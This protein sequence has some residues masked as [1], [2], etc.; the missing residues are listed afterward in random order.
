MPLTVYFVR[1]ANAVREQGED[2]P[3][4]PLSDLGKK[5]AER[6]ARRLAD[7]HFDHI[8]SSSMLRAELTARLIHVYHKETPLSI[9]DDIR[10]VSH[11]H[12]I[13]ELLPDNPDVRA[14]IKRERDG[15]DRFVNYIHHNHRSGEHIL[16][17]CH[18][19]IMRTIIPVLSGKDP[20]QNVLMEFSNTSLSILDVWANGESVLILSN[21][22]KHLLAKQVT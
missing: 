18:G 15:V 19:N 7:F 5:Q 11:Y 8:Y 13:P 22:I 2:K 12:F 21:C 3:D 14:N 1:H 10:E 4:P 16:V 9:L 20:A 17:V 6:L